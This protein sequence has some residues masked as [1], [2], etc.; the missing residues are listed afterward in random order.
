[1]FAL[2]KSG[3]SVYFFY[4]IK[5]SK[6]EYNDE[7]REK[8]NIDNIKKWNSFDSTSQNEDILMARD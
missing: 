6:A 4:G 2:S 7:L 3:F 5:S 1:M 8:I